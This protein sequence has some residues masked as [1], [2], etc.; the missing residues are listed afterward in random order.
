MMDEP[1]QH[2]IRLYTYSAWANRQVIDA[3]SSP[4]TAPPKTQTLMAHIIAA[5]WL[6]LERVQSKPQSVPVWPQWSAAERR[7]RFDGVVSGWETLLEGI[8]AENLQQTV[9]YTNTRGESWSSVLSDIITH[10]VM[11]GVYHRGQI[12]SE[13]RTAGIDPVYTDFI[14]AARQGEI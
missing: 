12:A 9:T 14:H 13:M 6:W 8:Q 2:F 7:S 10:V 3:L 1:V 4:D 11:H 5:E